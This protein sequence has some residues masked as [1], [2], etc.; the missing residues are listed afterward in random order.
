MNLRE[1]VPARAMITFWLSAPQDMPISI[2]EGTEVS[3]TQT[4]TQPSIIFTTDENFVI[5]PP[6]LKTVQAYVVNEDNEREYRQ[7]DAT[8]LI[9]GLEN[10]ETF[11]ATP[12][13]ATPSILASTTT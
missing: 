9:K 3:S 4:E 13:R 1:P 2:P 7:Y 6:R 12:A 11:S 5:R 8:Q 10:V